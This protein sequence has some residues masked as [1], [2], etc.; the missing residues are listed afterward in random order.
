MR[1]RQLLLFG[2]VLCVGCSSSGSEPGLS[3]FTGAWTISTATTMETC[4]DNGVS[5]MASETT[6]AG[7]VLVFDA[8]GSSGLTYTSSPGCVFDFTVSGDTATLSGGPVNCSTTT[9]GGLL[10]GEIASYTLSTSDGQ[11]LTGTATGSGTE[12]GA[13]CTFSLRFTATR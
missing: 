4:D 2:V 10:A 7:S 5:Q 6:G 9:N 1:G 8:S 3:N 12:S 11:N 13:S